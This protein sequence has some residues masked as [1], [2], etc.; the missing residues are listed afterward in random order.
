M[1]SMKSLVTL[2]ATVVLVGSTLIAAPASAA[3]ANVPDEL[4]KNGGTI[5]IVAA[6]ESKTLE[7]SPRKV[8]AQKKT[9][10]PYCSYKAKNQTV[11]KTYSRAGV[12]G[13]GGSKAT[14]R[15]G[16]YGKSGWGLR[17]IGEGHKRHWENKAAGSGWF[18]MMEFATK[19]TLKKPQSAVR[20]ANDTY[21][22]CAPV[23]LKYKGKTYDSFKT[24]VPVSHGGKNVITS[25]PAK[26]C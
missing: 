11:V 10:V 15:C 12:K 13:F 26:K 23:Q 2:G 6:G 24:N 3:E 1:K 22:Y 14:L 18:D 21:N 17:H 25:F 20:Q 16:A 5:E 19:Q 9:P 8:E 7:V 4:A